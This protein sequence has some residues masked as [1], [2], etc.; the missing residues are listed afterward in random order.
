[1]EPVTTGQIY[2]GAVPFVIIQVIM[3]GLVIAF[4]G[5]SCTTR[6]PAPGSTRHSI[7]NLDLPQM[8]GLPPLD[9]GTGGGALPG[10]EPPA[11]LPGL[12]PP[13]QPAPLPGLEPPPQQGTPPAN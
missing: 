11:P 2:W 1:M 4:P 9:L 6:A 7:Q 5:W 10:L 12:E 13:G 8:E 3:V